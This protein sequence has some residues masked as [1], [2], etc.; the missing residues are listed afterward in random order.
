MPRAEWDAELLHSAKDSVFEHI[1]DLFLYVFYE[2]LRIELLPFCVCALL[3]FLEPNV[4]NNVHA[5]K[6]VRYL[7]YFIYHD[8]SVIC[9][10]TQWHWQNLMSKY[11]LW[12]L[13][14]RMYGFGN[15]VNESSIWFICEAF[16]SLYG[17]T[18]WVKWLSLSALNLTFF[19]SCFPRN[20]LDRDTFSK[21]DPCKYFYFFHGWSTCFFLT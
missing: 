16:Y 18:F 7:L 4:E 20:L 13:M 10:K 14:K 11:V 8:G 2:A 3:I 15:N 12:L 5:L 19:L 1:F 17:W 9:L 21:S 6:K